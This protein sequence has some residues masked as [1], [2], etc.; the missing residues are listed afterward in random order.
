M[1]VVVRHRSIDVPW[2]VVHAREAGAGLGRTLV[3][4][5]QTPR[6]GDEFA[7]LLDELGGR[8]H[9]VALDLP[10]MGHSSPHP[11][12]D[13]VPAYAEAVATAIGTLDGPV[14]LLGHHT[15]AAVATEV[16]ALRPEA[17]SRLF[18]SSPP[19][20][21]AEQRAVRAARAGPGVDEV[22]RSDDGSHLRELWDGRAGFY[23]AGRPDL[24]ERFVADA[25]LTEDP[26]AG[27]RAVAAWRMEDALPLLADVTV[28]L[29]DHVAD[30]HAH[31]WTERWQAAFPSASTITIED[32]MVPFELTARRAARQLDELG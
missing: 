4:L 8:R 30:P 20:V 26:H 7:E 13:A 5:H 17:V 18:L 22:E 29:I 24:L 6:S 31:P 16:A 12:G 28:V 9:V 14:E 15:G 19:W 32:G 1:S 25:L 2:G 21:D 27:H 10:G 23:P 3:C 11:D